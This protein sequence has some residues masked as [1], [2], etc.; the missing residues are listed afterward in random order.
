MVGD[1]QGCLNGKTQPE[2]N[3]RMSANVYLFSFLKRK[4]TSI[5][6]RRKTL[7]Q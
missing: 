3:A 7:E 1:R 6:K 2:Q 5:P 4:Y